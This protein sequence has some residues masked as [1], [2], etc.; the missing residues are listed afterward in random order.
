VRFLLLLAAAI[1]TGCG[2][3]PDRSERDPTKD[4]W[5]PKA[6]EQL[7]A[8]NRDAEGQYQQ[9]KG[10]QAGALVEKGVPISNRLMAVEH[11]TLAATEA[12]SDLDDLY[13]RMLLGNRHWGWARL[14]F[15]KNLAR[16]RH[17]SPETPDTIRRRKQAEAEIDECDKHIDL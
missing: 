13:G 3:A 1:L 15:Q 12:A 8:I 9:H 14:Q 11:P 5:Y 7:V 2:P 4:G 16:W 17:W 10:D 6:V